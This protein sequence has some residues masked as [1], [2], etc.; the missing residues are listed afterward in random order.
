[1]SKKSCLDC[2]KRQV[3]YIF[4]DRYYPIKETLQDNFASNGKLTNED[5]EEICDLIKQNI[6]KNCASF[7]GSGKQ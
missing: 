7:H 1:M 3:C 4:W 5:I 2:D 6:A